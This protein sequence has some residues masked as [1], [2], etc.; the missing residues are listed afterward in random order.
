MVV[1]GHIIHIGKHTTITQPLHNTTR[2]QNVVFDIPAMGGDV[3]PCRQMA[4]V[5]L[6]EG[7]GR[8]KVKSYDQVKQAN[9]IVK[10]LNNTLMQ[11]EFFSNIALFLPSI[12]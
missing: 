2:D 5:V 12:A 3:L 10:W 8:S 11:V 4:Q 1:V 6:E 7:V 9:T